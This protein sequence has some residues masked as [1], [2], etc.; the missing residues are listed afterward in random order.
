MFPT[1]VVGLELVEGYATG[2]M[3]VIATGAIALVKCLLKQ[4]IAVLVIGS[5]LGSDGY[6]GKVEGDGAV[7][8]LSDAS[9]GYRQVAAAVRQLMIDS[10]CRLGVHGQTVVAIIWEWVG[11]LIVVRSAVVSG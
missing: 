2:E 3:S 11:L 6:L 5:V 10:S 1:A 9:N 4:H 7:G 8:M